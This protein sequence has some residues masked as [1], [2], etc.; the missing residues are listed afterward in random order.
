[1]VMLRQAVLRSPSLR[2]GPPRQPADT[3]QRR[4][5]WARWSSRRQIVVAE[6]GF[7]WRIPQ[8]GAG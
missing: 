8:S 1:M 7:P 3:D 5:G 2:F 4:F 6:P